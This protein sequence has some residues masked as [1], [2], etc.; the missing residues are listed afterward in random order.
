VARRRLSR[1]WF[2][3]PAPEVAADLLGCELLRTFPAAER[4]RVRIVETEA[5]EAEDPAS[6]SFRGFSS[7]SATMFGPP[8]HLY[9]YL[10]YGIH[11]CLNVVT[12]PPGHGAAVLVRAAEPL[13]GGDGMAHARDTCD[14]RSWCSG[15]G[16]LAQALELDLS[17][18]GCDVLGSGDVRLL[19]GDGLPADAIERG[20]RVGIGAGRA[21]PWR[22]V[23]R[24]SPWASRPSLSRPSRASRS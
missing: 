17:W 2:D 9:V 15:P 14:P 13:E 16:K 1:A 19:A 11:H 24:G 5:Y 12:G 4:R 21:M 10:I 23:E 18:D 7:R 22:F 8:G 3:R 6:H 20:P